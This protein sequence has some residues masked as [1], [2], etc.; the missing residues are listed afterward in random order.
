MEVSDND[1]GQVVVSACE[2][3]VLVPEEFWEDDHR[4]VSEEDSEEVD[5]HHH[6]HHRRCIHTCQTCIGRHIHIA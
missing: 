1:V 6:H 5:I 3:E 4:H 2:D